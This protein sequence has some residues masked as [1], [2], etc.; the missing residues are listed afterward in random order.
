MDQFAEAP[1][2]KAPPFKVD[3]DLYPM[4]K[5]AKKHVE[6][7]QDYLHA[8]FPQYNEEGLYEVALTIWRMA[9][10]F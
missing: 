9:K 8:C 6:K 10:E 2:V 3:E 1:V 4:S 5:N 7:I